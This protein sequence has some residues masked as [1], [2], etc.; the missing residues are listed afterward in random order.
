VFI[1][2]LDEEEI[3]GLDKGPGRVIILDDQQY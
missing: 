3:K 2:K 1:E